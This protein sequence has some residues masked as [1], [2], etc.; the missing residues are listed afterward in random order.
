DVQKIMDDAK[1][2]VIYFS[3]GSMMKSASFPATLKRDL[4]KMF[5]GLRETVLWKFEE[6][7]TDL[8][9]NVHVFKWLPQLSVLG[10]P[11]CKLFITHAGILSISEAIHVGVPIISVPMY[12]DQFLNAHRAVQKGF[13]R[14]IL[15]EMN[16]VQQLQE[17]IEDMTSDP[18]YHKN[19]KEVAVAFHHRLVSPSAELVHWVEH[20]IVTRGAPHLRSKALRMPF[21]QKYYLDLA[22]LVILCIS[23]LG[24]ALKLLR[25][26][27][28]KVDVK[29]KTK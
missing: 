12:G 3:M 20:V 7:F 14:R 26:M 19:M 4:I 11:N 9:K 16:F 8:P 2:G 23:M 22:V 29:K 1:H 18:S 27:R 10:H 21:Y 28:G 25:N 24:F 13:S 6:E 15:L 5:A 17:A